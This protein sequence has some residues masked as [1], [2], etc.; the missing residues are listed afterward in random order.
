MGPQLDSCGR[1]EAKSEA[2]AGSALQWGRNLIVAE[3]KFP[4]ASSGLVAHAS[5]GPQLDS[6]GRTRKPFRETSR[7]HA[8]MGPQLDSCGR[9]KVPRVPHGRRPGLQWGRNLIVAEV[10][11]R[12][13]RLDR[14]R[15]ASMGPQLDSCGRIAHKDSYPNVSEAASM[16]PQLDSCGRRKCAVIVSVAGTGFNG[17]AT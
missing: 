5:M 11:V 2:G 1:Y 16:G 6:C 7:P 12:S 3:G 17:A 13:G 8:S 9:S 4:A 15:D 14:G 10:G